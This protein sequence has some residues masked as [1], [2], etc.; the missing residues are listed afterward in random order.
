MN[1]DA[2]IDRL[3]AAAAEAGIETAEVYCMA[4]EQFSANAVDE[5]INKYQVSTTRGL[6][7]RGSVNG[8]IGYAATEAFDDEAIGQLV[9]GVKESAA[10]TEAED[11]DEIYAGDAEYPTLEKEECDLEKVTPEQKLNMLQAMSKTV[12]GAD[13][14]IWKVR[15]S[16]GSQRVTIRLKNSYGLDL[17]GEDQVIYAYSMPIAKDG[18]ATASGFE[19]GFGRKAESIDPEKIGKA[20][21]EKTVAQLHASPLET[22]E[23][24][25]VIHSD[26]MRSLLAT[27]SG[28]F[29]AE[30]TQQKLSLL[31]G[32]EGTKIASD[33]VTLIDDPLL[34]GGFGSRTFDD[35]GSACFTKAVID[36]GVLKTLLHDRKTA[37]KQGVKSTGNASR[38]SYSSPVHVAPSNLYLQPGDKTLDELMQAVGNGLLLTEVSG[39]HAGANPLSGDFSLLSKGFV[40]E[41]GKK[42][43]PVEQITVAGNFYQLLKQISA[44]GND[45]AF[46]GETIGTPSVDAGTLKVS[47]K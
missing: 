39:L 18:D 31:G 35:E 4:N 9:E 37:K 26:A 17:S 25:T 27:F 23:Y 41:N 3:L 15:G 45:L 40:I 30:N 33:V 20:A 8:K 29:S 42:G 14:R 12:L 10:L 5:E 7:L 36:H 16:I 22:G 24:R 1:M 43:R 47:G 13:K 34:K 44:V 46:E 19:V 21:V 38:A 2:F 28:M 11:Q 32:K 6:S